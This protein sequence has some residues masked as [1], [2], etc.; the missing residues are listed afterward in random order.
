MAGPLPMTTGRR[1]ALA[2]GTPLALATIGFTGLSLVAAVGQ[3]SYRVNLNLPA[4][5][6][7][8]SLALDSSDVTIG[9]VGGRQV[10]VRGAA[11]YAL[12]TSQVSW[13]RTS[14]SEGTGL[15]VSTRCH[16]IT[17]NCSFDLNV[18][19]PVTPAAVISTSSGNLTAHDL[20]GRLTLRSESGDVQVA[21]LS[22]PVSIAGGSGNVTGAGLSGTQL[23]VHQT[24]GDISM[25]GVASA[26]VTAADQSGN[27]TLRFSKAPAHVVVRNESGDVTLVLPPGSTTYQVNASTNSGT[28]S[29]SGVPRSSLSQ[30]LITV[31]A[32]S[33]NVTV[34]SG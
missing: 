5:G 25:T 17:G 1:I 16:Q 8:V 33:G 12:V 9:P 15:A 14:S 24:S 30:H 34:V 3:G 22:G 7:P 13:Q 21:R 27:V 10:L 19:L 18:G 28:T 4:Q 6:R 26:E 31:T 20:P 11:H 23:S 32:T 2:L 29:V